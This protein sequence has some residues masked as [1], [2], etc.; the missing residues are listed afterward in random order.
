MR[1]EFSKA[2]LPVAKNRTRLLSSA[3]NPSLIVEQFLFWRI[4]LNSYFPLSSQH[5]YRLIFGG[6]NVFEWQKLQAAPAKV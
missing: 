6:V 4:K 1:I 2:R 5:R 3:A